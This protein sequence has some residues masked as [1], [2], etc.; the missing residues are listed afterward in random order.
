MGTSAL[1]KQLNLKTKSIV[2]LQATLD[3]KSRFLFDQ[4]D[5]FQNKDRS[6]YYL[7]RTIEARNRDLSELRKDA[8]EL[9]PAVARSGFASSVEEGEAKIAS[10][11]TATDELEAELHAAELR[12]KALKHQAD[13]YGG[14]VNRMDNGALSGEAKI[15]DE[16]QKILGGLEAECRAE[17]EEVD[18]TKAAIAAVQDDLT[19][20]KT[21]FNSLDQFRV[22]AIFRIFT[23]K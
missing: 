4:H 20:I 8:E 3:E 9:E 6:I 22:D 5:M 17:H 2:E 21:D 13:I 16:L 12:V 14:V 10:A 15:K 23:L 1:E 11:T 18:N 7:E 19:N